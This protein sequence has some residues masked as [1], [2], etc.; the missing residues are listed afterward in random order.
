M[1]R[2]RADEATRLL[3]GFIEKTPE[4]EGAYVTLAKIHLSADR[5]REGLAVLERLLQRNPTNPV[6]L[7]LVRQWKP[8]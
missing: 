8:R 4:F 6:A 1:A 2:G 7:E 3:E 5:T